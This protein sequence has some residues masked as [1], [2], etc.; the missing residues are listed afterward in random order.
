MLGSVGGSGLTQQLRPL[1]CRHSLP[2]PRMAG[3]K[4]IGSISINWGAVEHGVHP[5]CPWWCW[6]RE[7]TPLFKAGLWGQPGRRQA[8]GSQLPRASAPVGPGPGWPSAQGLVM[9]PGLALKRPW[10]PVAP[11]APEGSPTDAFSPR[12]LRP[13]AGTR[14]HTLT[15]AHAHAHIP[16]SAGSHA[17][18][19]GTPSRRRVT[20][21]GRSSAT[22]RPRPSWPMLWD[23]NAFPPP[24]GRL[25]R[26]GALGAPGRP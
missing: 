6:W 23:F 4:A 18:A 26:R 22:R 10:R 20:G 3:L 2:P 17:P 1:S 24:R 13:C 25:G 19:V 14:S 5:R 21:A 16:A 9:P 11:A 7:E 12:P 8:P 15:A